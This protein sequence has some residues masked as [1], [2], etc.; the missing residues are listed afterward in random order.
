MDSR[1]GYASHLSYDEAHPIILPAVRSA[2][3]ISLTALKVLS[4]HNKLH[5]G[6]WTT[7]SLVRQKFWILHSYRSIRKALQN[8][9]ECDKF[10]RKPFSQK[11]AKIPSKRPDKETHLRPMLGSEKLVNHMTVF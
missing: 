8:C 6:P 1:T 7:L 10:K 11:M 3:E 9:T 5:S 2:I 4:S